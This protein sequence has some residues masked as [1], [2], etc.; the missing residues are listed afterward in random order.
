MSEANKAFIRRLYHE[1]YNRGR[2]ELIREMYA[3]D[4]E[5]HIAGIPED[6]FGPQAVE[7][8]VAMTLT[9][10]PSIH[11]TIDD[12]IASGDRVV[13]SISFNG[14]FQGDI[15]GISPR[16]NLSWWRRIDIYR[17]VRDRIVEQWGDRDDFTVLQRLGV[18]VPP[19]EDERPVPREFGRL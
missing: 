9:A 17:V 8:L 10:F 15:N 3:P 5:L 16:R 1:V 13:A 18:G 19:V 4:V 12:L 14:A 11:V 2:T 7:Q 6:P